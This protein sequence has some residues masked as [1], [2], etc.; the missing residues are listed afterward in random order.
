MPTRII[1]DRTYQDGEVKKYESTR[2]EIRQYR[3][4]NI[5]QQDR[6]D[7]ARNEALQNRESSAN[8]N[9]DQPLVTGAS[10]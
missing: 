9:A 6:D 10:G 2:T 8:R 1:I 5:A 7:A 3:Q 4:A